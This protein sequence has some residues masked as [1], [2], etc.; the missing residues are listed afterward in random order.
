M[1]DFNEATRVKIP[2]LVHLTRIGYT[3]F[4]KISE[5]DAGTIYDPDTNILLNVFKN[6]RDEWHQEYHDFCQPF[7]GNL[8]HD[9]LR[10]SCFHHQHTPKQDD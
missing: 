10:F 9:A 5:E 1:Q 6:C 3:Y 7:Q 2:G 8:R 4:G